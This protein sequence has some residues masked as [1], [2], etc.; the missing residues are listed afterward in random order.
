MP[1]PEFQVVAAI[2]RR[3]ARAAARTAATPAAAPLP[4]PVARYDRYEGQYVNRNTR[5]RSGL[6]SA[7]EKAEYVPT[8]LFQT[9]FD[10]D[11]L[12]ATPEMIRCLSVVPHV[13]SPTVTEDTWD[14]TYRVQSAG[15]RENVTTHARKIGD[16]HVLR[17][18]ASFTDWTDWHAP[19]VEPRPRITSDARHAD[20]PTVQLQYPN[21]D[22]VTV[23]LA[24]FVSYAQAHNHAYNE[25]QQRNAAANSYRASR[26][27][28]S[29]E[30]H[31]AAGL[32]AAGSLMQGLD[33]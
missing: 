15:W 14:Y 31:R 33:A 2:Q 5:D 4:V 23:P 24:R 30:T 27:L 7:I 28:T 1:S 17:G 32:R 11:A 29:A 16:R 3:K 9:D 26:E 10:M 21:G 18:A 8:V 12:H 19:L 20:G 13:P 6:L 25:N 22:N